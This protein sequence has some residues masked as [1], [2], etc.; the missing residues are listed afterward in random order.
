MTLVNSTSSTP[1]TPLI[2]A[3]ARSK[4]CRRDSGSS[5]PLSG[6]S[7]LTVK[8][9]AASKPSGRVCKLTTERVSSDAT[10]MSVNAK[11]TWA[12][13]STLRARLPA[14]PP[15]PERPSRSAAAGPEEDA[16]TAGKRPNASGATSETRRVKASTL[17]LNSAIKKTS[18]WPAETQIKASF[19]A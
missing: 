9:S 19:S 5:Y 3:R 11:D 17:P 18:S 2:S 13:T 15:S 14:R 10:I 7:I 16:R 6:R 8:T 4:N 1:G 12:H